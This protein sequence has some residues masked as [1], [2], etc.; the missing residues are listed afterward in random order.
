M[1]QRLMIGIAVV[2]MAISTG[3]ARAAVIV[4]TGPANTGGGLILDESQW[5]AAQFTTASDHVITDVL[6]WMGLQNEPGGTLTVAIYTDAGQIPGTQL[7]ASQFTL[8]S[9]ERDWYGP[10]GLSWAL[11][12]GT[13]WVAFEE[14]A[15]DTLGLAV[16]PFPAAMPLPQGA[17]RH[18]NSSTPGWIGNNDLDFGV[19]IHAMVVPEPQAYALML[20]GLGLLGF[21]ALRRRGI[22]PK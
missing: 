19:Q 9:L 20:A 10:T 15:G 13:Y 12:A 3:A 7:F 11:A 4:D 21:A 2:A 8:S 22:S 18:P 16:M 5:L 6:G 17:V 14:R 1:L